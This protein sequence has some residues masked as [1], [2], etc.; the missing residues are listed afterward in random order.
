MPTSASIRPTNAHFYAPA[1]SSA[2]TPPR[3][4][5]HRRS[6][7]PVA[8]FFGGPE[9]K[10]ASSFKRFPAPPPSGEPDIA[11]LGRRRHRIAGKCGPHLAQ[12]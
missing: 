2:G 5:G 4:R 7:R 11:E 10:P 12:P 9:A 1:S 3:L 8:D 6:L